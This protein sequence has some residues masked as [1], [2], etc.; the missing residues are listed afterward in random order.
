MSTHALV[1]GEHGQAKFKAFKFIQAP[2]VEAVK[3]GHC[4]RIALEEGLC[5]LSRVLV[6]GCAVVEESSLDGNG[7]LLLFV[8]TP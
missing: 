1:S 7:N 2:G 6:G 5:I 3:P 8:F 4:I